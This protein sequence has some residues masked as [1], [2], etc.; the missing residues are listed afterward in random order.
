MTIGILGFGAYI[1]RHRLQRAAIHA[2]N[3]WFAGGLKGLARGERAVAGWDEDP[4]TMSV[5][6]ARDALHGFDRAR[7]SSVSLASTTLPFADRSNAGDKHIYL[8]ITIG[9]KRFV[10]RVDGFSHVF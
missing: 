8:L 4:I 9:E 3:K 1:P 5:Q 7:V 2:T 6:A 10:Q